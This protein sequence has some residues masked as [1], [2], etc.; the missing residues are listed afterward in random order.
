[1]RD[2]A[3]ALGDCRELVLHWQHIADSTRQKAIDWEKSSNYNA[4]ALGASRANEKHQESIA[5][6]NG[7]KYAEANRKAKHRGVIVVLLILWNGFTA[8][9]I[10]T[11]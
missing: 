3:A 1:M 7:Q 11:H 5:V 10:I 2:S 9:Y 6:S 8:A 4:S